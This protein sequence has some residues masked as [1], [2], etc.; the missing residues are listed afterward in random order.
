[1]NLDEW[2]FVVLR[3]AVLFIVIAGTAAGLR[4]AGSSANG[5]L[6]F[7]AALLIGS[8]IFAALIYDHF[9]LARWLF[10]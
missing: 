8:S 1:M 3:Y 2:V 5:Y 4:Q 7:M 6:A 9:K 10:G